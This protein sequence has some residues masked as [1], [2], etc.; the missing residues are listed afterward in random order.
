MPVT[1]E[2][3]EKREQRK[4][5]ENVLDETGRVL[6]AVDFDSESGEI[7]AIRPT[8]YVN[9]EG[10][11]EQP[12][13]H[14]YLTDEKGNLTTERATRTEARDAKKRYLIVTALLI[15]NDTMLVQQRSSKKTIDPEKT[16]S[17]AHGVAKEVFSADRQR[18]TDG[19][20]ASAI[21][22][23]LEMNEEL[24]HDA[25]PFTIRIWPGSHDQLYAYADDQALNDPNTVWVI[26]EVYL[27]DDAY[28]LGSPPHHPRTRALFSGVIFSQTEP[29]ISIDPN[30]LSGYS[31]EKPS[32]VFAD[33]TT[34]ADLPRSALTV[35]EETLKDSPLVRRYGWKLAENLLRRYQGI[36]K[37]RP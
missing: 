28:P 30:E 19:R 7:I 37:D 23:A 32:E 29:A 22:A 1:R 33:Q 31:W 5:T 4:R 6:C 15:H 13:E 14:I 36:E 10:T 16:S 25:D 9:I 34:T 11:A 3:L 35:I 20:T 18:L 17:S 12:N 24:R 26:P 8:R 21:N 2:F 27:P